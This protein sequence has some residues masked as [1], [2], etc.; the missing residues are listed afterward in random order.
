MCRRVGVCTRVCMCDC[1][2]VCTCARVRVRYRCHLFCSEC[3]PFSS[4]S[5][6]LL[7]GSRSNTR[8]LVVR[9]VFAP[10]SIDPSVRVPSHLKTSV[11]PNA[12]KLLS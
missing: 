6:R 3:P 9:A 12:R 8:G 5:C 10:P 11:S 1:M 2:H 4:L 7:A